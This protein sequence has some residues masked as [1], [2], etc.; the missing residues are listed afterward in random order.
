MSNDVELAI[1]TALKANTAICSTSFVGASPNQRIYRRKLPVSPTFPAITVT[2]ID[3]IADRDTNTGGWAHT[4]IQCTAWVSS[5][6]PEDALSKLIR[7][8]LHRKK[9]TLM[10]AGTGKVYIVMIRDA[11]SVPDENTEIPIYMEH[12]DFIILY[13]YKEV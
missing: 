10:T 3:D 7:K 11:G 5:P 2:K 9:N 12:R 1:I 4:R 13:D 8:A 6:G